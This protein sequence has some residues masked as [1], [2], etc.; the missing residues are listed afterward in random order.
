M[1]KIG[2]TD[3]DMKFLL[4][5]TNDSKKKALEASFLHCPYFSDH[6]IEIRTCES[7]SGIVDMPLTLRELYDGARNRAKS[8]RDSDPTSDYYI[9]MESGIAPSESNVYI[10]ISVVYIEN[11]VGE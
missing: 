6:I 1:V 8:A 5:T 11:F 10:V 9:G 2:L 7:P 3:Q 4:A